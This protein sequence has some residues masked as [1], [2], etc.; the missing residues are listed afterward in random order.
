MDM[1]VL[2]AQRTCRYT[3]EFGPEVLL[4]MSESQYGDD[5]DLMRCAR[6]EH[7]VS[8]D[9]DAVEIFRLKVDRNEIERRL[10][11]A[12]ETVVAEIIDQPDDYRR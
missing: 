12:H 8:G 1:F 5:H 7:L 11:S 4:C 9:Y 6:N 2:M 3:G 10:Q